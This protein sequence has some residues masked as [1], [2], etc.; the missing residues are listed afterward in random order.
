MTSSSC[1]KAT[2]SRGWRSALRGESGH[3]RIAADG[4]IGTGPQTGGVRG[5]GGGS[6][7]RRRSSFRLLRY[8]GGSR[9]PGLRWRRRRESKPSS[10]RSGKSL[11][12]GGDKSPRYCRRDTR[13]WCRYWPGWSWRC[14]FWCRVLYGL[15]R[16]DWL[17][18]LSRRSH[19]GDGYPAGGIACGADDLPGAGRLADVEKQCAHASYAGHRDAG[20]GDG[21]VCG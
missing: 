4:R 9:A 7:G 21:L 13:H 5:H 20:R 2:G 17:Q 6:S 11:Q 18:R 14:A 1:R 19:P 3:R 16:G 10:A 8:A 12:G 15:T